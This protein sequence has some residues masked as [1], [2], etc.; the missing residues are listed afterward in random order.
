MLDPTET[1]IILRN[2]KGPDGSV[3]LLVTTGGLSLLVWVL[4]YL[5]KAS[6]ISLPAYPFSLNLCSSMSL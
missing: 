3:V 1:G 6:I 5:E 2:K 4:R